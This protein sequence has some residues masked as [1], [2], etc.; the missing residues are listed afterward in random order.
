MTQ[1]G[2]AIA[3]YHK[4][5][6]AEPYKDL[7]WAHELQARMKAQNLVLGG[8]P[9]SPV[10]RPHFITRRQYTN[11][12]K[13]AESL[14]NAVDRVETMAINSPAL[15]SRMEMLPAEKMLA[16]VDP[17]YPYF[18]VTSLL[19]T[20]LHNGTLRFA[21]FNPNTPTGVAYNDALAD[22]FMEAPPMKEFRK[23]YSLE[24][25]PGMKFLLQAI[26]KAYKEYGGKNKRPNIA[27]LEFKHAFNGTETGESG[28]IAEYFKREGL[29]TEIVAPEQLEYRNN[30]LRRGEFA[31]DLVF[32][33]IKVH[34]FLMRYDLTHPLLRAYREGTVCVVN[35]FRS[36]LTQK[37][38]F[39]DLLTDDNLT[40]SFPA[41]EKKAIRDF[42]P[43]TR[44]VS[45]AKTTYQDEKVDLPD[46][47][48]KNRTKLVLRPNDDSAD[49][50]SFHGAQTDDT[51]WEKA[52]KTA[53]RNPYV[54]QEVVEP[55]YDMFPL[56]QYGHLEMRKMRIDLHPH[57][58]LGKVHGCSSWL[59]AVTSSGFSTLAGVAPTFILESK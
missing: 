40:A 43:W 30:V 49:Q 50:H 23:R 33:R 14:V 32:R 28:L 21:Q 31:I 52:L 47:I 34:E 13:A 11:L 37:K 26:L 19:D 41:V 42:V 3:R 53:L 48:L 55:V 17:K 35:N 1:L 24:R 16:S 9:V 20:H 12:V 29:Q 57:T 8:K 58:Y 54:V 4:L 5:L 15:M 6:E 51:R 2:E 39:F 56:L 59:T 10:L 25:L 18:A 38:A 44:V 45:T 46:F 36:E 22:L 27:I 7:A